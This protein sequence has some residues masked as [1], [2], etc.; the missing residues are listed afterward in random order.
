MTICCY[1]M[2][3]LMYTHSY[4]EVASLASKLKLVYEQFTY[5]FKMDFAS[6]SQAH[7]VPTDAGRRS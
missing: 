2:Y 7:P 1:A 6:R 4:I 5:D 3:I